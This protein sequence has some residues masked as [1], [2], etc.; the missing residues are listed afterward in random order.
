MHHFLLASLAFLCCQP[1]DSSDPDM[2]G[3]LD[4]IYEPIKDVSYEYEGSLT[5]ADPPDHMGVNSPS[6]KPYESFSGSFLFRADGSFKLESFQHQYPRNAKGQPV[7]TTTK[8]ASIDRRTVRYDE[9]RGIGGA[10]TKDSV[11]HETFAFGTSGHLFLVPYL[12]AFARYPEKRAMHTG[13]ATVD[14]RTCEVFSF[15]I[16]P[17]YEKGSSEKNRTYRFFLDLERG[18]HAIRVEILKGSNLD[19]RIV[20]VVLER[21]KGD[22]GV[23]VWLPVRGRYEALV[24]QIGSGRGSRLTY[25]D[26][27]TSSEV[28]SVIK[29]SLRINSGV[30]DDQ[31]RLRFKDGTLIKDGITGK[32]IRTGREE[33]KRPENLVQAQQR[34][35][36]FIREAEAQGKEVTA[37]SAAREGSWTSTTWIPWAVALGVTLLCGMVLV[38]Q[39]MGA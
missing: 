16:G 6:A 35:N 11:F 22:D 28:V 4:V 37:S 2:I 8:M 36:G 25:V 3:F 21:F 19:V 10:K 1:G 17:D 15:V 38:R 32:S 20:D 24:S 5:I 14:G 33:A 34:L 31:F 13:T 7:I 18:G 27:P 9:Q 26:Y 12:K 29:R 30:S 23:Q 39:R